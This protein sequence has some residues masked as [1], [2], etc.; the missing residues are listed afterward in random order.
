MRSDYE[1]QETKI[2]TLAAAFKHLRKATTNEAIDLVY[3]T[4]LKK[5][6]DYMCKTG[7]R[8]YVHLNKHTA[9]LKRRNA[10]VEVGE[11]VGDLGRLEKVYR[12]VG[13]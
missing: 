12:Y 2:A 6:E 7:W 4:D 5:G 11:K 3:K 10:L 1:K 8:Y 13:E 9:T